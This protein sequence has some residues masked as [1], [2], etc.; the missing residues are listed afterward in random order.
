LAWSTP[1]AI[2]LVL[3]LVKLCSVAIAGG[4]A[5]SD[6]AKRDAGALGGDVAA[7]NVVNVVEPEKA[8]FAAG[9]LAVL[10][11]RLDDADMQFSAALARTDPARSC[12]ARIN[13]ELVRETLGDRAA[14]ALDTNSAVTRYR[15]ALADV[16][17][18]P[19]G[20]FTG[21]TDSDE[22]R[23]ALLDNAATRLSGKIDAARVAPAA[24]PPAAGVP[25][26]PP[27]VASARDQPDGQLR[28]HPGGGDPLQRLQQILRDAAAAQNGR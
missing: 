28:L 6:F 20:C 23:R 4:S 25:P 2:V 1:I 13:R 5:G 17:Q 7:L 16:E 10:G 12:P 22:K 8:Y 19:K 15:S 21:S 14:R 18:A 11:D 9:T 26:S 27:S 24:P 3:T